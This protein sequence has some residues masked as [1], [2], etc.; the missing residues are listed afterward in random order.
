[1]GVAFATANP[2]LRNPCPKAHPRSTRACRSVVRRARSGRQI[3]SRSRL[4]AS[5]AVCLQSSH[6]GCH[7][8]SG[9]RLRRRLLSTVPRCRGTTRLEHPLHSRACAGSARDLDA[10]RADIGNTASVRGRSVRSLWC[11]CHG[12]TCWARTGDLLARKDP[13][14]LHAAINSQ[15]HRAVSTALYNVI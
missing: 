4:R 7:L 13:L 10:K 3:A 11:G 15:R 6:R 1:M 2:C 5:S 14:L 9:S 8:R 12:R